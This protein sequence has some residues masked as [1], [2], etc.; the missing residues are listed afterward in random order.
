MSTDLY[1][2]IYIYIHT[3]LYVH[4]YIDIHNIYIYI[5]IH[6]Q[7]CTDP[8][9]AELKTFAMQLSD[10]PQVSGMKTS[11]HLDSQDA[12][13]VFLLGYAENETKA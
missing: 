3:F 7:I 10:K 8:Q 11:R 4:I 13:T 9:G 1:T 2:Y 5:Y 12:L 6:T